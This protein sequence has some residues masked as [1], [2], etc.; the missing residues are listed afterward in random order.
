MHID[1]TDLSALDVYKL[2]MGIVVPRPIA[3]VSTI[4]KGGLV[5]VAPF[6]SFTFVSNDPPLLQIGVW[7]ENGLRK[8]TARNIFALRCFVIN[9]VSK[10]LLPTAN[11][12][13]ARYAPHESEADL[14]GIGLLPS[15]AIAAPR[16]ARAPIQ[17]ECVLHSSIEYGSDGAEAIIGEV[18]RFHIE[19]RLIEE[20][21]IDQRELAP[22]AR[23]GGPTYATL[24]EYLHMP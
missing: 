21:K 17:M 12:T 13:S 7:R 10:A 6:S 20:G 8:D 4:D 3:W 15:E 1:P 19:D 5:N 24:G 11:A 22:V 16:I 23:L 9:I 18:V 2:L 14:L